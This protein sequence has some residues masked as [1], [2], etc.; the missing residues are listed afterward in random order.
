MERTPELATLHEQVPAAVQRRDVL[1]HHAMEVADAL[2]RVF[3]PGYSDDDSDARF[4][5]FTPRRM[6]LRLREDSSDSVSRAKHLRASQAK[7]KQLLLKRG[8][9]LFSP[10]VLLVGKMCIDGRTATI[11]KIVRV[12]S[13]RDENVGFEDDYIFSRDRLVQLRDVILLDAKTLT[14]GVKA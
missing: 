2:G 8:N 5:S 11:N 3:V 13:N 12:N 10:H 7:A 14:F 4:K 6:G 9:E 1:R